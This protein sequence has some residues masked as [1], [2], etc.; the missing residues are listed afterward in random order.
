MFEKLGFKTKLL[1][2]Y[3][4]ILSLMLIITLVVFFSVK[5]LV[6]NF[7]WVDHTHKVLQKALHLEAAAVNMETGMRGYLLAGKQD[8]LAPYDQGKNSFNTILASLQET[9]ADNEAQVQLLAEISTTIG[10]WQVSVTEPVIELRRTIGNAKT[11]NDMSDVVKEAKGKQ[12]FDKFRGQL[13]TFIKRE[14]TLMQ[15]RQEKAKTSEDITE[16][17]QLNGWVEHTYKVIAQAQAIVASAVD[18]ET[19]MRGFL[20]AGQDEFLDPYNTGKIQFYKLIEEL[21][22]T[23]SDNPAQVMLLGQTKKTIDDWISIVVEQQIALRREIGDSKTMDDMAD[24]VAE[25]RGKVYFDKFRGQIKTFMGRESGLMNIRNESLSSIEA[26]VINTSIFGT[27]FGIIVGIVIALL[28]TRYVMRLLGGEPAYIAEIANQVAAGDLDI[29]LTSDGPSVGIYAAMEKMM[30]ALK[31]K[32]KLAERIAAGELDLEVNLAS[33]K[34]ALGLALQK[35]VINLNDVLGMTKS[36]SVEISQGS[37]SVSVTS[38]SLS[39]GAKVQAE[40]LVNISASL[41]QLTHQINDNAESAK[42]A[43]QL[44]SEAQQESKAGSDKMNEMVTAMSEISEANQNISAFITTIDEIAAQTNLLAL[45]A[46]IEAARAGEQG[47]GF[48]VV[49]EEVRNLAARSTIA[50]EETSKLIN[51]SVEKTN[52]GSAIASETA[53]SLQKIFSSVSRTSE[54]VSQMA[55]ASSEQ[56]IGAETINQGVAEID[57]VTQQNNETAQ[58]SAVAAEQLSTQAEQLRVMLDRFKLKA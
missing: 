58:E 15:K 25:A 30:K 19:G 20:L 36:S 7:G 35:M 17:K 47:R 8:F 1:L 34:D 5:S 27:L 14:R 3:A 10:D 44:A 13:N 48:A 40:S 39:A 38:S 55:N 2:G 46:A 32:T 51:G 18:M 21:S 42:M 53:E 11:M 26:V 43:N 9:V 54:L 6:K 49:A 23:V 45:N 12:Y 37:E 41:N 52:L 4:V 24:V 28:L 33:D 31:Q 56:A 50:A 16:L 22:N 29:E 57:S